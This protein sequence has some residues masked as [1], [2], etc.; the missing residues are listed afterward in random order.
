VVGGVLVQHV[1]F[2]LKSYLH[3]SSSPAQHPQVPLSAAKGEPLVNVHKGS[4]SSNNNKHKKA[5]V[6]S[7][8][9]RDSLSL[10]DIAAGDVGEWI[11]EKTATSRQAP[12]VESSQALLQQLASVLQ[13]SKTMREEVKSATA[14]Y[15]LGRVV[16]REEGGR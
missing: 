6:V 13:K 9:E 15:G 16:R 4:S 1:C 3:F 14:G 11:N 12:V 8:S 2:P 10:D 5:V 7:A